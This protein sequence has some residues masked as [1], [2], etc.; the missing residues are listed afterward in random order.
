LEE[1]LKVTRPVGFSIELV[2]KLRPPSEQFALQPCP[3][4]PPF[5]FKPGVIVRLI[6]SKLPLQA[7]QECQV[8]RHR[9][10]AVLHLGDFL[11][12]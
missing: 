2:E 10:I 12:D 9:L 6:G 11:V 1:F 8:S 4:G 7:A 3:F 5:R